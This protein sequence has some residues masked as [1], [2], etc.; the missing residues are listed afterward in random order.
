MWKYVVFFKF[1]FQTNSDIVGTLHMLGFVFAV[2]SVTPFEFIMHGES[3][4]QFVSASVEP[5]AALSLCRQK[6]RVQKSRN[7]YRIFFIGMFTVIRYVEYV[8]KYTLFV[9]EIKD[10]PNVVPSQEI[11]M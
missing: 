4:L 7:F 3:C 1:V 5:I 10:Y 11:F 2:G 8:W 9:S 6:I